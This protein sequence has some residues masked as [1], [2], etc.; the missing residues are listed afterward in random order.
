MYQYN[1]NTSILNQSFIQKVV[2]HYNLGTGM[3]QANQTY[4]IDLKAI[5]GEYLNKQIDQ[6]KTI[7]EFRNRITNTKYGS[8]LIKIM[9]S[10][11]KTK[12]NF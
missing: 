8:I 10:K 1:Y 7:E 11:L 9:T 3:T 5:Y 4:T 6:R 2:K 12:L